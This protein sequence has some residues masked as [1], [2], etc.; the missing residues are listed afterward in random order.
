[1]EVL[2]R[3]FGSAAKVFIVL[4][5]L[6]VVL[7]GCNTKEVSVKDEYAYTFRLGESH[8]DDHPTTLA[9]FEFARL[10][11]EKSDG[12]IKIIVHTNKVLGEERDMIEQV[13]FGAIDFVRVSTG[14]LSEFVPKLNVIQLPYLYRDGDHMWAVLNS[15]IGDDFL[16]S[17]EEAGF[18]GLTFMD[19][20]A[21]SF[22]N[23]REAIES[24]EDLSGMKI[25]VMQSAMMTDMINALGAKA[26]AMPYGEVYGALQ[27]GEVDG[28][29]NNWP[30]YET[31][32]HYDGAKYFSVDEHIRVPEML[33]AS[34]IALEHLS[35]E[36][37]ALIREAALEAQIYQRELWAE[38]SASSRTVAVDAGVQ[39]NVIENREAFR[40]AILPL[41]EK[42]AADYLDMVDRI[43]QME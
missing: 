4:S 41:Y 32:S 26:I 11:E 28:A 23:S 5:L 2:K 19:A 20:G 17:V 29:E 25:R 22:Y 10:V 27:T 42:Y 12:R 43:Q 38:H 31:A 36:D 15:E 33:I 8:P 14:P 3:M 1:M 40:E 39:I 18:I 6:S 16:A 24:L 7:S 37:M 35:D 34:Q 21:R 13:Q 9:D 30:S